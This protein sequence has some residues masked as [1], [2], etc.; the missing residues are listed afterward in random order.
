MKQA[1]TFKVMQRFL[2]PIRTGAKPVEGRI[3]NGTP[4]TFKPGDEIRF[5]SPP[6]ED[7]CVVCTIK[8]IDTYSS[9]KEMLDAV[10]FENCIP[11]AKN[12][13]EALEV[14]H[15]IPGYQERA[16]EHGVLAIHLTH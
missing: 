11:D 12:V 14:Y 9:F 8:K 4:A 3:N 7:T 2:D 10:G 13:K 5:Y 16:K 1:H 15:S 6:N